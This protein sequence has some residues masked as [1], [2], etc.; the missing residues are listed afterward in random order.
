MSK[1]NLVP[2][3]EAW[4]V[5]VVEDDFIIAYDLEE[6]LTDLGASEVRIARNLVEATKQLA[7]WRPTLALVDWRLGDGTASEFVGCL[8]GAGV[9]VAIVSGSSKS[10]MRCLEEQSVVFLQK[11]VADA[12]LSAAV[13]ELL[14]GQ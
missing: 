14:R 13:D 8:V 10:E 11:P 9:R 3:P 1:P 5:L 6:R 12:A 2:V 4:S 7:S